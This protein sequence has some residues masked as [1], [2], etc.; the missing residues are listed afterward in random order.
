MYGELTV[1]TC[2]LAE[3][4]SALWCVDVLDI[5]CQGYAQI[6]VFCE[7][8]SKRTKSNTSENILTSLEPLEGR[9]I[10]LGLKSGLKSTG[11]TKP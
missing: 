4:W 2:G 11:V 3:I 10:L 1:F 5:S 8:R 9:N 6:S 7:H